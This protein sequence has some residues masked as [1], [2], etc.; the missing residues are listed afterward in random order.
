[1]LL[2]RSEYLARQASWGLPSLANTAGSGSGD[3]TSGE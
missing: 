3:A 2:P 1:V